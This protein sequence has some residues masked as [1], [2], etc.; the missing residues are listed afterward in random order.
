[1][2]APKVRSAGRDRRRKK[3]TMIQ[4]GQYRI[5]S[6]REQLLVPIAEKLKIKTFPQLMDMALDE[7]IAK[8]QVPAKPE[9]PL[10]TRKE[11]SIRKRLAELAH[12]M[13][14]TETTVRR[15]IMQLPPDQV[16]RK[17]AIDI[18][19]VDDYRQYIK[20]HPLHSS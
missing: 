5:D 16:Q 3:E 6:A 8:H 19:I 18:R 15:E 17:Y 12:D 9:P 14:I 1:M 20:Q 10:E 13:R 2:T 7:F 4:Q 11:A